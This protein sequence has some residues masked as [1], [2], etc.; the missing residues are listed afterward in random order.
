MRRTRDAS[1]F[2][3]DGG[4]KRFQRLGR[5]LWWFWSPYEAHEILVHSISPCTLAT[6]GEV[7]EFVVV[8]CSHNNCLLRLSGQ[9]VSEYNEKG[10]EFL[11]QVFNEPRYLEE[12]T[13]L[14]ELMKSTDDV[15]VDWDED[16]D[17]VEEEE[18]FEIM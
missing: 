17:E 2:V 1:R 4:V 6:H 16:E 8:E 14:A 10:F 15:C 9:V 7:V 13:G 5:L 18:N 3:R 12:L 11:L